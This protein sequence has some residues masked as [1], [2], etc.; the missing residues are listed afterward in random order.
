MVERGL[1]QDA[2]E[3]KVRDVVVEVDRI[4]QIIDKIEVRHMVDES[5]ERHCEKGGKG[6]EDRENSVLR[7]IIQ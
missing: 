3:D 4:V 6:F 1:I 5:L 2:I 7:M